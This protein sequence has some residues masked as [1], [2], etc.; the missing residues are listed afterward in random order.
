MKPS[1]DLKAAKTAR[2]V[3]PGRRDRVHDGRRV[4]R[5]DAHLAHRAVRSINVR[6]DR[7]VR[8]IP[9]ERPLVQ[10]RGRGRVAFPR[11]RRVGRVSGLVRELRRVVARDG[12]PPDVGGKVAERAN[13][14][15]VDVSTGPF[16]RAR[17][18]CRDAGRPNAVEYEIIRV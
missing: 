10:E 13:L 16:D 5:K 8:A 14:G 2:T 1:N 11:R 3:L 17:R 12:K 4:A 7:V 18:A 9:E 15:P 6:V